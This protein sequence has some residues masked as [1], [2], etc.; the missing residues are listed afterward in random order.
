MG[1]IRYRGS[2]SVLRQDLQKIGLETTKIGFDNRHWDHIY[3]ALKLYKQLHGH[4]RIPANYIIPDNSHEW[5]REL[6][7]LKLGY[8]CKN[9]RYRGD[10]IKGPGNEKYR[11]LL[12]EIG[13]EF[14]KANRRI[15]RLGLNV[16]QS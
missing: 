14:H 9:I 6:Y 8:R 4:L 11:R 5:P 1:N 10:F 2:F 12:E 7:N 13:F 15:T 16:D 3:S